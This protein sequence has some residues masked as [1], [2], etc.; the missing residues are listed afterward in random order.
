[1]GDFYACSA[2]IPCAPVLKR[3]AAAFGSYCGLT[4]CGYVQGGAI[5]NF[6]VGFIDGVVGC[7]I[8]RSVRCEPCSSVIVRYLEHASQVD[9]EITAVPYKKGML[10]RTCGGYLHRHRKHACIISRNCF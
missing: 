8:N 1:V 10:S 9:T 3:I 2:N 7:Q 6:V 5:I 4:V